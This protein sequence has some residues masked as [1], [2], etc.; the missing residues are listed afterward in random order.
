MDNRIGKLLK[1]RAELARLRLFPHLIDAKLSQTSEKVTACEAQVLEWLEMLDKH[2]D[3]DTELANWSTLVQQLDAEIA[4]Y[5]VSLAAMQQT[6][7]RA[8]KAWTEAVNVGTTIK[9]QRERTRQE[10][11]T[12]T[13]LTKRVHTNTILEER[14][15][16]I[17]QQQIDQISARATKNLEGV[18]QLDIVKQDEMARVA[19]DLERLEQLSLILQDKQSKLNKS[20]DEIE[21]LAGHIR[22]LEE[23]IKQDAV[24]LEQSM[25]RGRQ[26]LD[27]VLQ[28]IVQYQEES[29]DLDYRLNSMRDST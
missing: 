4:A 5:S 3:I 10:V 24:Q 8:D 19:P 9:Q 25:V 22:A 28:R 7:K 18:K 29:K 20:Q 13:V 21:T 15:V 14:W 1:R 6:L 17:L 27:S 26:E 2:A 23:Q 11:C 12:M 16:P